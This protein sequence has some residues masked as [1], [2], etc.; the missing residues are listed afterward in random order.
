MLSKSLIA[1]PAKI[2]MHAYICGV[3]YYED[4]AIATFQPIGNKYSLG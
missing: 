2:F 4:Y 3:L 1:M